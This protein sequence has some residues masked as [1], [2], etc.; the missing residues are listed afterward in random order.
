[1]LTFANRFLD[2]ALYIYCADIRETSPQEDHQFFH[3]Y[4]VKDETVKLQIYFFL[5]P[6]KRL[7]SPSELDPFGLITFA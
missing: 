7:V 6:A 5:L 4:I 2:V 1:M 3:T